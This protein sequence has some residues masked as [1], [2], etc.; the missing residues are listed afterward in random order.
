[1]GLGHRTSCRRAAPPVFPSDTLSTHLIHAPGVAA[2]HRWGLL[3]RV[4]ATGCPPISTYSLDFGPFVIS[5]TPRPDHGVAT[6]YAPRRTVLDNILVGAAADAGAEIREGFNVDEIVVEEGVVVGARGHGRDGRTVLERGRVVIGADGRNSFVART[7][8]PER[9]R[10]KPR[11]EGGFYT[12][13]S[14]LPGRR[15]GQ[16]PGDVRARTS[17]R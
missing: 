11:L 12:Y 17:L 14:G 6:A 16:L 5:G 3:E 9:Y 7:L 13:W 2:L 10:E 15:R 4:A 1:M 8:R